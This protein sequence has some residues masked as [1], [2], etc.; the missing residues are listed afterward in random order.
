MATT[1]L[2]KLLLWE[3][4]LGSCY[5]LVSNR[6]CCVYLLVVY[7]PYFVSIQYVP[8]LILGEKMIGCF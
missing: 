3:G 2:I 8:C 1:E 4:V 5:R 7:F 6:L